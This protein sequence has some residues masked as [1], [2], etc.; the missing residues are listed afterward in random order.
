MYNWSKTDFSKL[1]TK[2]LQEIRQLEQLI[3]FGLNGEKISRK[4]LV[5]YFDQLDIEPKRKK[6]L[7]L[8]LW[9]S[10][11]SPHGKKRSSI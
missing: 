1:P 4:K 7:S 10:T 11:T 8:L 9:N 6:F 5:K 2:A 3:N